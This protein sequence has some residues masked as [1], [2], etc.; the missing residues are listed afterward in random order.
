M[1]NYWSDRS[2]VVLGGNGFIGKHLVE[3]LKTLGAKLVL[4]KIIDARDLDNCIHLMQNVDTVMNLAAVVGGIEFNRKNPG[5]LFYDNSLIQLVPLEAARVV[6]VK[7][8]LQ[9]S[10]ACVYPADAP[11]PNVE[12]WGRKAEPEYTNRGYGWGKRVGELAAEFYIDQYDMSIAVAR[13]FNAYGPGDHFGERSHVIPALIKRVFEAK[14][15]IVVWGTGQPT[16][17]FLYVDDFVDGLLLCAEKGDGLGP[18][19]IGTDEETSIK[20]LVELIVDISGKDLQIL[21]DIKK[22][23]GQPRRASDNRMAKEVLGFEAKIS[24][25]KG[26]W[27][28][29]NWYRDEYGK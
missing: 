9:V 13:P 22:P 24:L 12:E 11:V 29:I 15:D 4:P 25:E 5:R 20:E 10:S 6:G 18:I 26:L 19:N 23:D 21:F 8:Y 7:N 27:R 3:K 14:D 2:V 16:R 1:R 28:T 17:S